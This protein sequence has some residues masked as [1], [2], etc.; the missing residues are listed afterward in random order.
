MAKYS[1]ESAG[2][3]QA[4]EKSSIS[5]LSARYRAFRYGKSDNKIVI[6]RRISANKYEFIGLRDTPVTVEMEDFSFN[7]ISFGEWILEPIE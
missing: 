7:S 2:G 6:V 5:R 4:P 1:Q 3:S